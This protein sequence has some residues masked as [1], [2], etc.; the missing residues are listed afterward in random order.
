M[1]PIVMVAITGVWNRSDT[2][3]SFSGASRSN[4]QANMFLVP[5]MKPVGVHQMMASTKHSATNV[6]SHDGPGRKLTSAGR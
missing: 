4:D 5:I 3:V 6:S 1:Q 2:W